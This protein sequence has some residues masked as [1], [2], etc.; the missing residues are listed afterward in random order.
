MTATTKAKLTII[1]SIALTNETVLNA[2][3]VLP[4][5]KPLLLLMA[6]STKCIANGC[7]TLKE[8]NKRLEECKPLIDSF[9]KEWRTEL[10]E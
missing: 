8:L 6:E 5:N 9:F 7:N 1:S 3:I 10:S 2:L 4:Q